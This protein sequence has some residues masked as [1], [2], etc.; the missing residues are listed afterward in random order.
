MSL[1]QDDLIIA[2]ALNHVVKILID[3]R[4]VRNGGTGG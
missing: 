3:L 4:L 1:G 2:H